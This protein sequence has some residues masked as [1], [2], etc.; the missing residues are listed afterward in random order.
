MLN[1]HIVASAPVSDACL[2]KS[3]HI[4]HSSHS[5]LPSLNPHTGRLL[6]PAAVGGSHHRAAFVFLLICLDAA[7]CCQVYHSRTP[8]IIFNNTKAAPA[9]S[10]VGGNQWPHLLWVCV[11]GLYSHVCSLCEPVLYELAGFCIIL[12]TPCVHISPNM[13]ALIDA[14]I[15]VNNWKEMWAYP[16][17]QP[18][19]GMG[20]CEMGYCRIMMS[21]L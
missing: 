18:G 13:H 20:L 9:P 21:Y 8:R 12:F 4:I 16:L 17:W 5:P 15:N 11:R 19:A 14:R 10:R 3:T 7:A 2:S 6:S 1:V